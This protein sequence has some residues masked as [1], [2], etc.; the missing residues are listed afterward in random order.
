MRMSGV[1]LFLLV[2]SSVA[3]RLRFAP[4]SPSSS[5]H[6]VVTNDDDDDDDKKPRRFVL[7][8][9]DQDT[10]LV[11]LTIG[12]EEATNRAKPLLFRSP[13]SKFCLFS[14]DGS[15]YKLEAPV[16]PTS[17]GHNEDDTIEAATAVVGNNQGGSNCM[18]TDQEPKYV[19]MI[20]PDKDD[21]SPSL[22]VCGERLAWAPWGWTVR[23]KTVQLDGRDCSALHD[24]IHMG[25]QAIPGKAS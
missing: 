5:Y 13:E 7:G 10:G 18:V 12:P 24:G 15:E 19:K 6:F 17:M 11:N 20:L 25:L 16:A 3:G 1:T 14:L 8:L 2:T 9:L 22:Y 4:R 21:R 23:S